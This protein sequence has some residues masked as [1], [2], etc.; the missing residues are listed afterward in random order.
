[1]A[2]GEL[3][4]NMS[5]NALDVFLRGKG[6]SPGLQDKRQHS[7]LLREGEEVLA[8]LSVPQRTDFPD[9]AGALLLALR[10]LAEMEEQSVGEVVEDVSSS[11][12]DTIRVRLQGGVHDRGRVR[13]ADA[14]KMVA[15]VRELMLAGAIAVSKTQAVLPTRASRQVES[16]ID[17]LEVAAPEKGSFVVR[18]LAPLPSLLS[19]FA[20]ETPGSPAEP[21]VRQATRRTI[22]IV[23]ATLDAAQE[24]KKRKD[25]D[26]F[27]EHVEAGVSANIC[28]ALLHVTAANPAVSVDVAAS[29][30]GRRPEEAAT[31]RRVH[32]PGELAPWIQR[33]API[34]RGRQPDKPVVCQGLVVRLT[35]DKLAG[36]QELGILNTSGHGPRRVR[37]TLNP[38]QFEKAIAALGMDREVRVKGIITRRGPVSYMYQPEEF[39]IAEKPATHL[40]KAKNELRRDRL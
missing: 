38:R 35:E 16:F 33:A 31:P 25:I 7:W 9:Y 29:W 4:R 26:V 13:L 37:V 19:E 11:G 2:E 39:D 15:G 22:E 8:H 20:V 36:A 1:M 24:A 14:T 30:G 6:W 28:E 12:A 17:S 10:R 5:P 34:L 40:K 23:G 32:L 27:K 18:V 3:A 21:F